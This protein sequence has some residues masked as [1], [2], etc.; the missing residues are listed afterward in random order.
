MEDFHD[1]ESEFDME[2]IRI[3]GETIRVLH[4]KGLWQK[5]QLTVFCY[6]SYYFCFITL[7]SV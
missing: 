2:I 7:I 5:E 4:K 6:R 3:P 1:N